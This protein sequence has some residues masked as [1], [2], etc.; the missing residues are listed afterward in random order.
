MLEEFQR[1]YGIKPL[2]KVYLICTG[3]GAGHVYR[4]LEDYPEVKHLYHIS[5]IPPHA[6]QPEWHIMR[7]QGP[8]QFGTEFSVEK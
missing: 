7:W 8:I 3:E 1:L 4:L 6:P 5:T 2:E